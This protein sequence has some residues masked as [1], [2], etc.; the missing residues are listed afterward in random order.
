MATGKNVRAA[1]A[2]CL[3]QVFDKGQS[4]TEVLTKQQQKVADKDQALLQEMCFGCTRYFSS[5][6]A[7][8]QQLL[9]KKLKGKQRVFHYLIIV[10]LYQINHMRT[11]AHAAVAE[12]VQGVVALKAPGLKGLINACLRNFQR[13]QQA[14]ETKIRN[15]VTQFDHP[16]WFIKRVQSAYPNDWQDILTANQQKA[17]MWL[18]VHTRNI[19]V[20]KFCNA[21][22]E[23]NITFEQPLSQPSAILL[24]HPYPVE[25]IPGFADGWFAVQDGAAQ[26]AAHLLPINVSDTVFDACAAPGGKTCHILDL[27]DCEVTAADVDQNR[28]ERVSENF[29]RLGVNAKLLCEDLTKSNTINK[30]ADYDHILV[31][32]PCSATGVIRRHPDIKWLRRNDDINELAKTQA[33]ILKRLW[34]KVKTGGTMLYATCS[35]LPEENQQQMVAFLAQHSD[36]KLLPILDNESIENPGW[37]ILPGEQGMDGFYYCL[38]QKNITLLES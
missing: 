11:P 3:F 32:A 4:L 10:G 38:I 17:P 36:A 16:S 18:R 30:L 25:K 19:S 12:T 33:T 37:Q 23:Q 14:L 9:T 8:T 31:D 1:A 35:I 24:S 7:I 5:L 29:A 6:D 26:Q 20:D 22:T 21:L 2:E 27:H 28:L 13:N 34:D 15:T